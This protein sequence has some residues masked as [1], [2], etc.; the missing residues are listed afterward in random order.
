M[1]LAANAARMIRTRGTTITLTRTANAPS[2]PETPDVPGTPAETAYTLDAFVKGATEQYIDG[3]TVLASDLMV[4]ASPKAQLAGAPVDI[5]PQMG[6]R[7]T[8]DGKEK[9]IKRILPAPAA[10]S[11]ALFRI[12]VAS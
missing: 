11:A 10:G 9:E 5:V 7:L 2:D 8:I 3:T 12:F 1:S 4:V 6:D